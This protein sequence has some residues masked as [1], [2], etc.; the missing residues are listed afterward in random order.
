MKGVTL[1][2]GEVDAPNSFNDAMAAAAIMAVGTPDYFGSASAYV[3]AS[4]AKRID[5]PYLILLIGDTEY[6]ADW[7]YPESDAFVERVSVADL[8]DQNA[9]AYDAVKR[10]TERME[11]KLNG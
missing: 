5:K 10:L 1:T 2:A 3:L 9:I 4:E 8:C 6:P 7:P 11:T